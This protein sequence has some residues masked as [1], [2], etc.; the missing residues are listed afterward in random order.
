M[1]HRALFTV[2]PS[3]AHNVKCFL[4]T[5]SEGLRT[6]WPTFSQPPHSSVLNFLLVFFIAVIKYL[7]KSIWKGGL[8][9][10]ADQSSAIHHDSPGAGGAVWFMEMTREKRTGPVSAVAGF[11][12]LPFYPVQNPSP[13]S[14]GSVFLLHLCLRQNPHMDPQVYLMTNSQMYPEVCLVGDSQMYL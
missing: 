9:W 7:T 10:F 11:L 4:E 6:K 3:V 5:I 1:T 14:S 2:R 12:F 13:L 8:C